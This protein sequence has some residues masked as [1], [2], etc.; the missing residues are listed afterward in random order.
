MKQVRRTPISYYGG[1]Q[2]MVAHIL[3][4]IPPHKIYVEPFFGGGAIY[5]S[6]E[7]SPVEVINDLNGEVINFYTVLQ[8][9]YLKLN[10]LI[11]ATLHSREQYQ[12]AMHVYKR[13]H[14][15][16]EVKRAWAFWILTNSGWSSKVGAWGYD[17][18]GAS[19]NKKIDGKKIEFG[20]Q[21]ARRMEA[22]QIECNDANKVITSRDTEETFFYVD[23]PYINTHMGHYEGY[24]DQMYRE[25]LRV[26]S[27]VKGKFLLSSY[28]SEI[29]EE[30]VLDHGWHQISYTKQLCTSKGKKKVEV[31]TANYNI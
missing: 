12:D 21:L 7:K 6:K 13:P 15:F 4:L 29:L 19:M 17:I 10:T 22:T 16:D 26:L 20:P 18:K 24:T 30:F 2:M 5:F 1:K 11:Q 3:P 27:K 9:E 14:L 8:T 25:L 28:P 31:L 23:P